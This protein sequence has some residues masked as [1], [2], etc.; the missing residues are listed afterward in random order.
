MCVFL[1]D[2]ANGLSG[3]VDRTAAIGSSS[4]RE[5]LPKKRV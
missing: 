2:V 4:F 1:P 5:D 3:L